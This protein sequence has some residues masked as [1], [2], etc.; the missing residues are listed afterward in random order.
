MEYKEFFI[1]IVEYIFPS[2][3]IILS[4]FS[5][6]DSRKANKITN[7]LNELEEKLKRYELEEKEKER[8]QAEKALV[9]A[10][11]V[12]IAKGKYRLKV[13]NS[14]KATAYNVNFEVPSECEDMI[15]KDKV[16]YEFLEPGKSFEEI[17]IFYYG[18]LEK[19][20]IIITWENKNG[21]FFSKEQMLSI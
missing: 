13:W 5:F 18:A 10:R 12:K 7:R 16:P 14:G 8:E 6:R 20:K 4:I 2:I 19:F 21:E 17:V 3:A 1:A 15:M 9:D 11:I